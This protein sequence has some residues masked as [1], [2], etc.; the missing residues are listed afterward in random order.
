MLLGMLM[1]Y[2]YL[3][4]YNDTDKFKNIYDYL[5]YYRHYKGHKER[6]D[7]LENVKYFTAH[8]ICSAVLLPTSVV[9]LSAI[10]KVIQSLLLS[11]S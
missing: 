10:S 5:F 2:K 6:K 4:S 7:H 9:L 8:F 1:R 3:P 11:I